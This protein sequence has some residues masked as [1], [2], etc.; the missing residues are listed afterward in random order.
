MGMRFNPWNF[1]FFSISMAG[2]GFSFSTLSDSSSGHTSLHLPA[3]ISNLIVMSPLRSTLRI[4]RFVPV[5]Y[6]IQDWK[7]KQ[8]QRLWSM[9]M[10]VR[11]SVEKLRIRSPSLLS[12][13]TSVMP[14]SLHSFFSCSHHP[15]RGASPEGRRTSWGRCHLTCMGG[16]PMV[17]TRP[18]TGSMGGYTCRITSPLLEVILT[19]I[20]LPESLASET[21]D[22]MALGLS[23][24]SSTSM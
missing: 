5:G 20:H 17:W 1:I 19:I 12:S 6:S 16:M 8:D 24:T 15:R 2:S 14:S 3:P 22:L 13:E 18:V 9:A 4:A 21:C 10:V 23:G 7:G 11:C